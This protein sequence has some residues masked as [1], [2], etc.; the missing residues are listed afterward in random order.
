[1][2]IVKKIKQ[3]IITKKKINFFLYAKKSCKKL[4]LKDL[5][6]ACKEL[7][8]QKRVIVVFIVRMVI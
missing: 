4:K 3:M 6:Y 8:N 2:I 5:G 1:M 7:E